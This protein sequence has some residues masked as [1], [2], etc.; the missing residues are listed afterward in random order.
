MNHSMNNRTTIATAVL[1]VIAFISVS[2]F[3]QST[4]EN[5]TTPAP[6]HERQAP[7]VE[8]HLK[9]FDTLDF[10]V[11]SNQKWERLHGEPPCKPI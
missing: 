1:A 4:A 7:K 9:T 8:K 10:D 11:F 3:A 6:K 5:P 2:A